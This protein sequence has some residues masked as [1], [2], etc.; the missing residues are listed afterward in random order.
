[1]LAFA[2][3]VLGPLVGSEAKVDRLPQFSFA[4][5]LRELHLRDQRWLDPRSDSL[6][7]YPRGEGRSSRLQ[8]DEPRV[9]LLQRI[10]VEPGAHAADVAPSVV[11]PYGENERSEERPSAPRRGKARDHH[12]LPL[13]GLDF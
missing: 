3:H 10:V 12:L 7:L 13:R 5:P 4:R 9:K 8:L 6:V 11:L 2:D 1:M